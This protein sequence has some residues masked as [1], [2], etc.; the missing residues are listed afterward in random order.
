MKLSNMSHNEI[1]FGGI[2]QPLVESLEKNPRQRGKLSGQEVIISKKEV[3][4]IIAVDSENNIHLLITPAPDKDNNLTKLDL[5]GLKIANREWAVS[6]NK[7][8]KYL[9]ISC[10]TGILPS[11]KRPFLRFAEDVLFEISDSDVSPADAVYKTG[12]RWRKFWSPDVETEI[13]REWV[14]GLFGELLFLTDMIYRFGAGVVDSWMGPLGKDHD[15]QT[16]ND[17]AVEI[18]TS[19][20]TPFRISCNLRQLDASIFKILYIACYRLT[21][22]EKGLS[23][24]DLVK[25]IEKLM[26][27]EESSLDKF[28]ERLMATGYA[29]Q[30]EP[31]YNSFRL[32]Y[33]PASLFLVDNNFPKITES[34]FI[35]PPDHRITGIRYSLQL[36]GLTELKIDDIKDDLRRFRHEQK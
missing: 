30:L 24:S 16:G 33:S 2:L 35:N 11:F 12:V 32:D 27:N 28:Y 21:L 7:L 36:T 13:T 18:K 22:S 9:D 6:G 8:K 15:F 17:L 26:D 3:K 34:S 25:G 10:S 20:E 31:V 14:H 1:N 29:R 23:L 19:V 4:A 5:K